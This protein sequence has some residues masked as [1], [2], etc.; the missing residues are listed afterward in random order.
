L[1]G[2]DY[3]MHLRF[4]LMAARRQ[5]LLI[6]CDFEIDM[7]P[8]ASDEEGRASDGMPNALG[9]F[10]EAVTAATQGLNLYLLKWN[11]APVFAPGRYLPSV[12]SASGPTSASIP[13]D[14]GA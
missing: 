12:V 11:G 4:A 5:V 7:L 14:A 10:R 1:E 9:N 2:T 8:G 3:F 6:G 13:S